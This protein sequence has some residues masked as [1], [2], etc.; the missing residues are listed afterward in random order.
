MISYSALCFLLWQINLFGNRWGSWIQNHCTGF[1]VHCI[2]PVRDG[3][4]PDSFL[5][6]DLVPRSRSGL[7]VTDS[8]Y[9]PNRILQKVFLPPKPMWL[10]FCSSLHTHLPG[11]F[12]AVYG[13]WPWSEPCSLLSAALESKPTAPQI[14]HVTCYYLT[15]LC[16]TGSE[17][18]GHQREDGLC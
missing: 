12:E 2:C 13:S 6:A 8:V 9:C 7:H 15:P 5:F 4:G 18:R 17:R 16:I 10:D 3:S 14:P 1:E 11:L